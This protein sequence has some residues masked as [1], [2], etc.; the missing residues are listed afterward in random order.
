MAFSNPI[1]GGQGALI[2][3]A[4]KSPNYVAGVS[5]WTVNRDGSAEFNNGTFRGTVTA[6]AFVG[7]DFVMNS[8]GAFFYDGTPALH[9]MIASIAPAA[10]TDTFG[11]HYV[12]GPAAYDTGGDTGLFG[13]TVLAANAINFGTATANV[14]DP[15]ADASFVSGSGGQLNQESG[16][17]PA[18]A[19]ATA[20]G[21]QVTL[22]SGTVNTAT[23]AAGV[24]HVIATD[25]FG[26]SA[27]DWWLS[28]SLRACDTGGTPLVWQ[29]VA[30]GGVVLGTGWADDTTAGGTQKIQYRRDAQDN[31]IITGNVHNT[32]ATPA[33]TIFT[34]A[35]GYRP[36]ALQRPPATTRTG[37]V[38]TAN[39][40]SVSTSGAVSLT[41]AL[42][43][44]SVDVGLYPAPLP[45]GHLP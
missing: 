8:A 31:L 18:N 41:T 39:E 28:G 26:T 17:D 23:G 25:A 37:G 19:T 14:P 2:R 16:I 13:Y 27:L 15:L 44:A 6:A 33:A 45:L 38:N 43:A 9:N 34:L 3:P 24:P 42:A 1:T 36:L 22:L 4:V 35:A 40:L 21:A 30:N 20:D 11:N 5:G 12:A 7:T 29:T 10:G 32:S